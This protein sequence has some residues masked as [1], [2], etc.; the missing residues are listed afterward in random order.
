MSGGVT[1]RADKKHIYIVRAN[2]EVV[3]D[4]GRRFFRRTSHVDIAPGDAIVVPL[5][6]DRVRPLTAWQGISQV[7]YNIAIAVTAINRL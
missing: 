1:N 7:L 5:N 6:T 3:A 2:G 4:S